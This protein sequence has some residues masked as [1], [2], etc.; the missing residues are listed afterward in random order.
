MKMKNINSLPRLSQEIFF[1]TRHL[2]QRLSA[3]QPKAINLLNQVLSVALRRLRPPLSWDASLRLTKITSTQ[4]ELLLSGLNEAN[5]VERLTK[6]STL[7]WNWLWRLQ[8]GGEE[9]NITVRELHLRWH[10]NEKIGDKLQTVSDLYGRVQLPEVDRELALLDVQRTG[11][12]RFLGAVRFFDKD[13]SLVAMAEVE[14]NLSLRAEIS[15][16]RN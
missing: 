14:M 12:A 15:W 16:I 11:S 13:E 3:D 9:W 1:R 6:A 10:G 2:I 4:A 7:I 5:R 8:P